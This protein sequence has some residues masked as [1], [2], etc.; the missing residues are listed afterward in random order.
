MCLPSSER[1]GIYCQTYYIFAPLP[2][3]TACV[4]RWLVKPATKKNLSIHFLW[5]AAFL[6]STFFLMCFFS[7]QDTCITRGQIT[8]LFWADCKSGHYQ[9]SKKLAFPLNTFGVG[10]RAKLLQVLAIPPRPPISTSR[11]VYKLDDLTYERYKNTHISRKCTQLHPL[12]PGNGISD[13]SPPSSGWKLFV[14][15]V[16]KYLLAIWQAN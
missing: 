8:S 6:I 11:H 2:Y 5:R 13:L 16:K 10:G 3:H 15:S 14:K 4:L 7:L 9:A 1:T 12:T